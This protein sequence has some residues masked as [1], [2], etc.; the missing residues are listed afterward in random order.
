[1]TRTRLTPTQ[2]RKIL[3]FLHRCPRVYVGDEKQCRRFLNGVLWIARSGAQWRLL[4]RRYGKSNSVFKRFSRWCDHGVWEAMQQHFADDPDMQ[5][6]MIDSTIVRAHACAAGATKK[7][8]GQQAQAL[9]RSRGGFTT[10]I[11]AAVD[12]SGNPL[13]F[14]LTGG[15]RNDITQAEALVEGYEPEYVIADKG[16]DADWFRE[17]LQD[18]EIT[19]VI[20]PRAGR[21]SP[22]DY[23]RQLDGQRHKIECFI[24]KFKHYRRVF[25]RFE[26]LANHYLGMLSFVGTLILIR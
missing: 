25:S 20:P 13:R 21:N 6:V 4:P 3:L 10:K 8:G 11:H 2:W 26:K 18:E 5:Q 23:D 17:Q 14:V 12:A 1:M 22:H 7:R 19:P 9:G 16:Y 24:G 15:Q